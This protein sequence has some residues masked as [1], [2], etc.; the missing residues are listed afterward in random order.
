M[1]KT[2]LTNV[3][4]INWYGFN[5]VT[6]PIGENFTL[7][8][9]ENESGKSTIL[10]AI[11]YGFIGDSEF[12]KSSSNNNERTIVSYTRC[13][14][15]VDTME[16]ARPVEKYPNLTSHIALE[17]YDEINK[18]YFV[19]GIIIETNSTNNCQT[20]G[21][22]LENKKLESLDFTYKF[23]EST[24]VY[25]Y[26]EFQKEYGIKLM[27]KRDS[28]TKFMQMTGLKFSGQSLRKFQRKLRAIMSYNPKAKIEEFIKESVLEEHNVK[29]DKLKESKKSIDK[30]NKTLERINKEISLLDDILDDYKEYEN[31]T[32]TLKVDDIKIIYKELKTYKSNIEDYEKTFDINET[33]IEEKNRIIKEQKENYLKIENIYEDAKEQLKNDDAAK[34]I[35]DEKRKVNSLK[36]ECDKYRMLKETLEKFQSN[37]HMM[38]KS[39]YDHKKFVEDEEILEE[40]TKEQIDYGKKV[41]AVA[42]L[43]DVI[44]GFRDEVLKNGYE[45]N[46]QL[47]EIQKKISECNKKIDNYNKNK[48]DYS[49]QKENQYLLQEINNEFK[50][51]NLST[52]AKLACEYVVKVDEEWRDSIEAL[53]NIHRYSIIVEPKYF[54]IANEVLDKSEHKHVEIVNSPLLMSKKIEIVKDSLMN[55]LDI[56]NEVALQYFS[57][58]LGRVHAVNIED[59]SNYENAI[60]K[61]C[62]L[63]RNMSVTF[64]NKKKII[65]AYALGQ[66]AIKLNLS[67]VQK[68]LEN[69]EN[70]EK[71]ILKEKNNNKILNNQL[72]EYLE[73]F[74]EYDYDSYKKYRETSEQ[75]DFSKKNLEEL[76]K[77]LK[78]NLEYWTLKERVDKLLTEKNE[79]SDNIDALKKEIARVSFDNE[80]LKKDIES[81]KFKKKIDEEKL[82][83]YMPMNRSLIERA[84]KEYDA[85][86]KGDSKLGLMKNEVKKKEKER[87]GEL[88]IQILTKQNEYNNLKNEEDR[89]PFGIDNEGKYIAR[90]NQIWIDNKEEVQNKLR[91]QTSNYER[92]FKNEFVLNVYNNACSAK[93]DLLDINK[94]L[95]KLNFESKYAFKVEFLQDSS[96]YAKVLRYAEYLTKTNKISNGQT[97]FETLYGF[98]EGEIEE[99]EK[100]IEEIINKIINKNDEESIHKFADYRNYMSYEI[101]INNDNIID[102]KLSKQSGYNSGA[103]TQIP[104]TLILSAA[105]SMIYNA[106]INSTRLVFIDEPF[107]KMSQYNV[108][109]MLKF[110]ESQDFQVIFCAAD[111]LESIGSECDVL[112]PV[113]KIKSNNMQIGKVKFYKEL[114]NNG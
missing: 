101:I 17:Y 49:K 46:N 39:L 93:Q 5:N 82:A 22:A 106:R 20:Y 58:F 2:L 75:I 67:K 13:L 26:S 100:E 16:F 60:S 113:L 107:E 3:H 57:Y 59:V 51:R 38:L 68:E 97:M 18:K 56:K 95:R 19:L 64:L 41:H 98:E 72:K 11:R 89:L 87:A 29:F 78:N 55:Y 4:L 112:I 92:I 10:D 25:N 103:G 47:Q 40:L 45:I 66:E 36:N 21:Y 83:N 53:F 61:E 44:R 111:K 23:G 9:G 84:Q 76:E 63:S 96:D 32:T 50:R 37:V 90:R 62:K 114:V 65:G 71:D 35:E 81:E 77:A 1:A 91:E 6:I 28:M 74:K 80:Q 33:I 24:F 73:I 70:Q 27:N 88:N 8:A 48:F 108:K 31:I 79:I 42:K 12:N 104:Y 109:V 7:I 94:E 15:N 43:K 102:G 54:H 69:L 110:F 34:A 52:E 30:I 86:I 14:T 105:L 99:R 85:F